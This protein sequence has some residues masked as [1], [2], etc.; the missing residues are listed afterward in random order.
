MDPCDI[1]DAE[2]DGIQL[3]LAK[4]TE[5]DWVLTFMDSD[6]EKF[7]GSGK[8]VLLKGIN[9][10]VNENNDVILSLDSINE[11]T[12]DLGQVYFVATYDGQLEEASLSMTRAQEVK[13][14]LLRCIRLKTDEDREECGLK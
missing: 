9:K 5:G 13:N 8:E 10:I 2:G 14:N 6:E 4:N 11:N 7:G 12:I 3:S 1:S